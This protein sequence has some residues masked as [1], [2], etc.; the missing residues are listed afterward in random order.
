LTADR[1][2]LLAVDDEQTQLEDLARLLRASP[3]VREVECA[4][5]GRDALARVTNQPFD[6]IF[7]DVRM[8]DLDGL[9]LARVLR[10]FAAPPQ[11]VFVSA[12][13]EA[14]V[15]AFELH[16]LDYLRKPVARKRTEE[17]I[18][19]VLAAIDARPAATDPPPGRSAGEDE[20]IAVA[21]LHGGS[22][23][24][25]ARSTIQY[26]QSYGDFVRIVTGDGRYLLRATLA[27]IERRWEPFGFVRVHRQYVANLRCATELRP[28]LGG[29]AELTLVDGNTIPVA[30]RH[31]ADLGRRLSV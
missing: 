15:E 11:L 28:L 24:L 3:S 19:R 2:T 9:E 16:A 20:M 8:P 1:L 7:L 12:Y 22:T 30:R 4:S 6:A 13:D 29:T 25:L 5:D 26:V 23:R 10:R 21:T 18:E 27:E 14:A 31:A 17:A